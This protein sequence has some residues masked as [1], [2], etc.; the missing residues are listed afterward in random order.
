MPPLPLL[1]FVVG[2]GS[3]GAEIAAVRL[4]AP[5]FGASTV[6]WANTIGVVLVALSVGYWLGGR[7]ADRNPTMRGLCLVTLTAAVLLAVVPFAADPLLDLAV[8]ALDE[9]SAGAFFGSLVAVLILVAIPV[10]L[11][12]AVSPW[13]LRLAVERVE[14]AGQ[15]AG[16]LYALSTAGSLFGTLVSALLLIPLVGTR[17]TFLVFAL[18]IAIVAVWGLRPVH[19]YAL[20]PVAIAV[21]IALPVGTLKAS[22]D[23]RVIYEAETEYQYARVVEHADGSRALE[24][25]EGQAQHSIYEPDGVLTGDVWDG[26]LVLPFTV[27][28]R[29]PERIAILGNAAGTTARAYEALFPDTRVDGVEIDGE[30]SEIGRRFFDMNNPNLHLYHEDARPFLRRIDARYDVISV[31]AYRQPYIPFYLATEEFFELCRD[32]LADGGVLIVNAGHPEGQDDLEEVLS[33]TMAEVFPNV[34]RD[35]IEDTNTLIVASEAPVSA[36]NLR[37]AVPSLPRAI[38]RLALDEA[39]RLAPRLEGGDVYT[40]DKAPVEWLIDKSIVDYA[41]GDED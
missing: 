41:A 18:A 14:Q 6:V 19:R 21:L 23:G 17:R 8:D 36:A 7:W 10:M 40:D 16:R 4:L 22:D 37:R 26:H 31:D 25:N 39:G 12:G 27:L 29:P 20:A 38:R 33:A 2:T 28:D 35:P 32:R 13:A 34:M 1:V 11:L 5:Y 30:L 15:V 9:I 3:L 24:L